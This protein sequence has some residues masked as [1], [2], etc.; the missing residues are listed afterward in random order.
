MQAKSPSTAR[1][2]WLGL[3]LAVTVVLAGMTATAAT[4]TELSNVTLAPVSPSNDTTPTFSGTAAETPGVTVNVFVYAGT[5][6]EGDLVATASGPV[7]AGGQWT[8]GHVNEPLLEKG[9]RTFTAVAVLS[10]TREE[11]EAVSFVVDTEPPDVTLQAPRSPSNDNTPT[12]SGTASETTQVTVEIHAGTSLAGQLVTTATATGTGAGWTSGPLATA[13]PDGTFTA[14]ATQPSAIGNGEGSSDP[15]VTFTVDTAPPTVSLDQLPSPS[16]GARPIFSGTASDDTPV[17]VK[18]YSGARAEGTPIR[19]TSGEAEGG[20][21]VAERIGEK[22]ELPWGEYTAIASQPSSLANPAGSS[23][24]MTFVLEPIAPAVATEA[25]EE[26]TRTTAALYASV[27]PLGGEIDACDIE[28]GTTFTYGTRLECGFV[29]GLSAFPHASTTLVPVFVRIFGLTPSTTYHF[30]VA[31]VGEGGTASGADQTFTTQEPFRFDESDPPG[32][33]P[34]APA[35]TAKTAAAAVPAGAVE[36]LIAKQLAASWRGATIVGLLRKGVFKATFKAP[37]AG[38]AA[39]G[40]YYS[41]PASKRGKTSAS[42]RVLIASGKRTFHAAGKAALA[43][44]LTPA[45]RRL[46]RSASRIRLTAT[47]VFTPS[48]SRPVRTS[49]AFELKR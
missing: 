29:E 44:R 37:E 14:V 22:E 31:V 9:D 15:P 23:A 17:T 38:T 40:W 49:S 6:A 45:G 25:A 20:E 5:V 2:V 4:A 1:T 8:S 11:S 43:L 32:A 3:I 46:L 21:W 47:C 42:S 16:P 19:S 33:A 27:D 24:P 36:A 48:G 34:P 18:I 41:P 7:R 35:V 30:R 39:I 10:S 28:Y 13:L 26:V 12:F